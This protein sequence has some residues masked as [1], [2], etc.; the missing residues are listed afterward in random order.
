MT[1]PPS[2]EIQPPADSRP[3]SVDELLPEQARS[4]R[5]AQQA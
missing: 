3:L 1:W 2:N 4:L 5:E